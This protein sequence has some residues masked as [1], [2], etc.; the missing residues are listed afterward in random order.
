[1]WCEYLTQ[2]YNYPDRHDFYLAQIATEVRRGSIN[3]VHPNKVRMRDMI[4]KFDTKKKDVKN[5]TLEE[6]DRQ[7]KAFW[8]G[9]VGYKPKD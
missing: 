1:M 4:L 2:D 6:A 8:F 5:R 7:A 3:C 9:L